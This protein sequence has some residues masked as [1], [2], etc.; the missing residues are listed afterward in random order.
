MTMDWLFFLGR[1]RTRVLTEY[2]RLNVIMKVVEVHERGKAPELVLHFMHTGRDQKT[3]AEIRYTDVPKLGALFTDA[4]RWVG[5]L[6]AK[7]RTQ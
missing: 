6:L 3:F 5:N 7:V 1:T 4:E 2:V